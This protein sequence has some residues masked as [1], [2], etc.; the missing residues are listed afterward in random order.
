MSEHIPSPADAAAQQTAEDF[1]AEIADDG[2]RIFRM[3]E[4]PKV[5]ILTKNPELARRLE[6]RGARVFRPAHFTPAAD[7]PMGADRRVP[8]GPWE[9]DIEIQGVRVEGDLWEAAGAYQRGVKV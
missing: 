4:P 8:K 6:H 3:M 2:G 5:F 9:W 1:L 7:A